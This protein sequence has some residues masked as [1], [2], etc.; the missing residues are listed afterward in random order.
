MCTGR[1][2][3]GLEEREGFGEGRRVD[4]Y[5]QR[6]LVARRR[7]GRGRGGSSSV[8]ARPPEE[9]N[10]SDE[11]KGVGLW[12]VQVHL[13]PAPAL[14]VPDGRSDSTLISSDSCGVVFT[15]WCL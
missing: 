1:G 15:L 6:A 5:P 2:H 11:A 8:S 12:A 4:P 10:R 13:P 14:Q 7:R 3:R 9:R